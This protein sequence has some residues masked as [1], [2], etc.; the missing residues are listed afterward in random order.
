MERHIPEKGNLLER[1][2]WQGLSYFAI[3]LVTYG[4]SHNKQ[5]REVGVAYK[6]T[7]IIR[8][9]MDAM[10]GD[11]KIGTLTVSFSIGDSDAQYHNEIIKAPDKLVQIIK[12]P[13]EE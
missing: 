8:G 1:I 4:C 3:A 10:V 7:E 5:E 9:N 6:G 2:K 13:L 12:K 11:K